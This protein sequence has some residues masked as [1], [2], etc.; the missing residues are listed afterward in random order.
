MTGTLTPEARTGWFR[1]VRKILAAAEDNGLPL[2]RID[3]G[4][5]RIG[6]FGDP[7]DVRRLVAAAETALSEMLGVTFTPRTE[8]V[9]VSGTEF[10]YLE[11]GTACGLA[12]SISA[13]AGHVAEKRV[14]GRRLVEDAEW[15]R[16]PAGAPEAAGAPG[17][18]VAA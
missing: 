16:L 9:D 13:V 3:A 10:Y 11:A 15:V 7:A 6:V 4:N 1:A 5:A 8:I 17:T 14:T 12:V 2:P 18:G